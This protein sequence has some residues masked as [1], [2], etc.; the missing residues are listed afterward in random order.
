MIITAERTG[1]EGSDRADMDFDPADKEMLVASIA[2]A[3]AA[4]RR[5][6]LLLNVA[7]RWT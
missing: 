7:G 6:V 5:I 3:K 4:G 2:K 1:Q